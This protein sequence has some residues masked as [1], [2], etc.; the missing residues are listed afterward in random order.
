MASMIPHEAKDSSAWLASHPLWLHREVSQYRMPETRPSRESRAEQCTALSTPR[1]QVWRAAVRSLLQLSRTGETGSDRPLRFAL[2][3][4][5]CSGVRLTFPSRLTRRR[6]DAPPWGTCMSGLE[7]W[8]TSPIQSRHA[9]RRAVPPTGVLRRRRPA[10]RRQARTASSNPSQ[11]LGA[12]RP[13]RCAT[14]GAR[15]ESVDTQSPMRS[16]TVARGRKR[17][18]CVG[19]SGK[20]PPCLHW[21]IGSV[22]SGL[23]T[24]RESIAPLREL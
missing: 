19:L 18:G 17:P 22:A 24:T 2:T 3:P 16:W 6:Q 4:S 12:R 8:P 20:L 1:P 14:Q 11:P 5:T 23:P 21:L 9:A 13:G 15:C 7:D 10:G